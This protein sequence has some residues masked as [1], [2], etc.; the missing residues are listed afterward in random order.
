MRIT[1]AKGFYFQ[2][3]QSIEFD[4]S[5]LGLSL[6]AGQMKAGKS[7]LLDL[8]P[9]VL[10]GITSKDSAADD[11]RSWFSDGELTRGEVRVELPGEVLIITRIRGKRSAQNDFYF[12]VEG[13]E[14]EIRG[15]DASDTQKLLTGRLGVSADLYLAAGYLTQFSQADKFFVSKASQRRETLEPI[16]DQS[17]AIA[18]GEKASEARK[19]AKKLKETVTEGKAKL[20]GKVEAARNIIADSQRRASVWQEDLLSR[21]IIVSDAL[22]AWDEDQVFLLKGLEAEHEAWEQGRVVRVGQAEQVVAAWEERRQQRDLAARQVIQAWHEQ[23]ETKLAQIMATVDQWGID[24]G[25]KAMK[26]A[27]QLGLLDKSIIDPAHFKTQ[28]D[29]LRTQIKAADQANVELRTRSGEMAGLKSTV[30]SLQREYASLNAL[31]GTCPTCLGPAD[32]EHSQARK[33]A[34][35]AELVAVLDAQDILATTIANLE[36][37]VSVRAKL[38]EDFQGIGKKEAENKALIDRARILNDTVAVLRAETNPY[39]R[40]LEAA[41]AETNPHLN[42][43]QAVRDEI[44]PHLAGVEHAKT[45]VNPK[46]AELVSAHTRTNP[47]VDTLEALKVEVNPYTAQAET[48]VTGLSKLEKDLATE[49]TKLDTLEHEIN[50]LTWL[51]DKAFVLRGKILEAA[52]RRIETKTNEILEKY[53][54]AELRVSFTLP[55]SDKLEVEIMNEGYPCPFKQLSGGERTLLCR[56]FSFAYM[57]AA[58]DASGV[59]LE[60]LALDEALNGLDPDMKVKAFSMFQAMA[61]EYSTILVIDHHA[62]FK[63]LFPRQVLVTKSGAYS[64]IEHVDLD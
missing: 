61:E 17:F 28:A 8:A 45:E 51:Y 50:S 11:V 15:K 9:W 62:E 56:A 21:V 47:H 10:Y 64:Q 55:D 33:E 37:A 30:A 1:T 32:N 5:D 39:K 3:Y 23:Q 46:T 59:K 29:Q 35:T 34:I 40:Q 44:N 6:I 43:L 25:Q 19:A 31:E 63:Q 58:E 13:T 20:E 49:Q 48:H 52:V 2:S 12:Q 42:S 38:Y 54:D 57:K 60:V 18:L 41:R 16:A 7:T 53:F 22:S 27:D 4:Y 14:Q 36:A 26:I 24:Q